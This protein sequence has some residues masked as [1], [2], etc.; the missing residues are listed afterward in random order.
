MFQ[1]DYPAE[2]NIFI[3]RDE[4]INKLTKA[5]DERKNISVYGMARI[6]KTSIVKE[7]IRKYKLKS[8]S[9]IFCERTLTR[10]GNNQ[11]LLFSSINECIEEY[12]EENDISDRKIERL[13]KKIHQESYI[14]DYQDYNKIAQRLFELAGVTFWLVI[15]E[16]DYAG[17]SLSSS[18][19]IIREMVNEE[20]SFRIINISRNS[21]DTIFPLATD[22]SN[23]PGVIS[24]R[25]PIRG[26][27]EKD[28][29][30]Y[31]DAVKQ[32]KIDL[33]SAQI[34]ELR[35]FCG[36]VPF[37]WNI[38]M[39]RIVENCEYAKS[40]N[41]AKARIEIAYEDWYK[42]LCN[43]GKFLDCVSI[44]QKRQDIDS[45]FFN[46]YGILV[47]GKMSVPE[48]GN[49]ILRKNNSNSHDIIEKYLSFEPETIRTEAQLK[50]L[51]LIVSK[52][53]T[54]YT[55]L[56][57]ESNC[58]KAMYAKITCLKSLCEY[59]SEIKMAICEEEI[60][61]FH[62]IIERIE[63]FV[64]SERKNRKDSFVSYR[65]IG[66]ADIA[67]HVADNLKLHQRESFIDTRD[68]KSGKFD[69]QLIEAIKESPNFVLILSNGALDRCV[70]PGDYVRQE[71]EHAIKYNKNIISV[72]EP[73]FKFP[74][75]LP[76]SIKDISKYQC[77][78]YTGIENFNQFMDEFLKM[79]I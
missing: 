29:D 28:M 73:S 60:N 61:Q 78:Q 44:A 48:F 14:L 52:D 12:L 26:Y 47:D 1:T 31:F 63:A 6:G 22:G 50:Q 72:M 35:S 46:V 74:S 42:I 41:D 55:N 36:N 23:Y 65:R 79:L 15:D 13:L 45:R 20:N 18:I 2:G 64:R 39:S 43:N 7:T 8:K 75:E 77:V 62:Q 68:M 25:L 67:R 53:S 69:E 27:S 3:G 5:I 21:L 70:E 33:D 76:D 4:E 11:K 30:M 49:Y 24:V 10:D 57:K 32:R 56:Q 51:M 40:F 71:I 16:M 9:V 37:F 34:E 19:Q 58:I 59:D 66:G 54:N 17:I 38:F